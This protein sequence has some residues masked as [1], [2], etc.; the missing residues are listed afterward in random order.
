MD[1]TLVASLNQAGV[2]NIRAAGATTQLILVEGTSYS[3]AWSMYH[4]LTC[5]I[6]LTYS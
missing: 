3:G 5:T 2:N 6:S 4:G 1:V